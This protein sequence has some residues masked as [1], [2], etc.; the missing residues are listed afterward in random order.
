MAYANSTT[1]TNIVL[2]CSHLWKILATHQG[3]HWLLLSSAAAPLGLSG[4]PPGSKYNA[5]M[6]HLSSKQS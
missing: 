3:S 1:A 5:I 6:H 4:A 2:A